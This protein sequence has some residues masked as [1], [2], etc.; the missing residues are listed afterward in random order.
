METKKQT[1]NKRYIVYVE[2]ETL[3]LSSTFM[4]RLRQLMKLVYVNDI[5]KEKFS[6]SKQRISLTGNECLF[7]F[8]GLRKLTKVKNKLFH[9]FVKLLAKG[10]AFEE[11]GMT[12]LRYK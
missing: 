8:G 4:T 5:I 7:L 10:Y 1:S 12:I 2:N 3:K 11:K 6:A 9:Q